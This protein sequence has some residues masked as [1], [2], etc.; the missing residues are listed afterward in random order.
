MKCKKYMKSIQSKARTKQE[1][2]VRS[3]NH[4]QESMISTSKHHF[5]QENIC[6]LDAEMCNSFTSSL[7]SVHF[8]YELIDEVF[9]V[10][11]VS[12]LN[13]VICLH[14]HS[15]GWA[16]QFEGPQKVV[17]FLEILP[18]GEYFM[19]EIF[20]ADYASCSAEVV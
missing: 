15:P 17:C 20:D 3:T 16:A 14:P 11:V 19:D 8:P 10:A 2:L 13:E 12:S 4:H 7:R 9:P 18:H 6:S 1:K 5:Q